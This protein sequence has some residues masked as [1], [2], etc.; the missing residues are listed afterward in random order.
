MLKIKKSLDT[1][2]SESNENNEG[3]KNSELSVES[4]V[5]RS[6]KQGVP[7]EAI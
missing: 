4:F 3:L 7:S 2:N 1:S 6:R 5:I